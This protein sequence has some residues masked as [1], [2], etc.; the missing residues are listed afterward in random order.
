MNKSLK[1]KLQTSL[2]RGGYQGVSVLVFISDDPSSNPA[3]T[4]NL[5]CKISAWKERK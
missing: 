4:N 3:E 1:I 5:S 2:G